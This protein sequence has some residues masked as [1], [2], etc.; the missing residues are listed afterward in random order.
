MNIVE[1]MVS[2]LS[3][4]AMHSTLLFMIW[5]AIWVLLAALAISFAKLRTIRI[6]MERSLTASK[7]LE[8]QVR[9]LEDMLVATKFLTLKPEVFSD[10]DKT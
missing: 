1:S 5:L 10:K 3:S 6:T 2:G 4:A 9:Q 7:T 8:A